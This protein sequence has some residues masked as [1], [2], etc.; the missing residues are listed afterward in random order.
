MHRAEVERLAA[1][2]VTRPSD[3]W[4]L[5]ADLAELR[6]DDGDVDPELVGAYVAA[7]LKERPEWQRPQVAQVPCGPRGDTAD[8]APLWSDVLR[9]A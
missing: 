5:G 1:D 3:L 8:T 9:N 2:R 4:L 7:V 6:N